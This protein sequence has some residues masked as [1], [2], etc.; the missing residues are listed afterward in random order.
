VSDRAVGSADAS[1]ERRV[2]RPGFR[3]RVFGVLAVLLIG[4]AFSGMVLQRAVLRAR[5]DV[6]VDAAHDQE[7]TEVQNLST[8]SN[9]ETGEP[10]GTDVE[11]IFDTFLRRNV[12]D[13]DEVYITIIGDQP[14]RSSLADVRL[15]RDAALVQQWASLDAGA[16]GWTETAGGEVRWLASPL[17]VDGAKVGTFVIATFVD[18]DRKEIDDTLRVE[19]LVSLGVLA[20]ALAISWSVAGRLL[21][22][23]RDLTDNARGL[24]E[25]DLTA[26]IPVSG[27]DEIASLARSYNAMLDRLQGAFETQRRFVDDAGHELRTPITIIGGHLEL[28]GDDPEDRRETVALVTDELDRMSRMVD[29]LLVLAKAEQPRFIDPEPTDL[30]HLTT[31]LLDRARTMGERAWTVDEAAAGWVQADGQRLVQAT[32]NLVRNAVEHTEIG[33]EIALGTRLVG[34]QLQLWVRD[35][36]P[37]IAPADQERLFGRFAR[38][39]EGRRRSEGAGL[40]LSIVRAIAE[41]HGG[42]IA[43]ESDLG[44][45]ATFTITVPVAPTAPP[46]GAPDGDPDG[47]GGR[48]VPDPAPTDPTPAD[49][50]PR[51]TPWPAS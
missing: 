12:P 18:E 30:G 19:A 43:V 10:F 48:A 39:A 26:R 36:G 46:P 40:G 31:G 8:G 51:T 20:I 3:T 5:L 38:G 9:P 27:H 1:A 28:M 6:D 24:D 16:R 49:P 44:R 47:G 35:Q 34:G 41:A 21:R 11:A 4:A 50:T 2:R 22:P 7:L 32:L 25:R 37:G 33:D 17:A 42:T 13:D 29:D 45:G 14:Y 23:V 15:D